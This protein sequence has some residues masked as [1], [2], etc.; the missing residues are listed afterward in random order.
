MTDWENRSFEKASVYCLIFPDKLLICLFH[1]WQNSQNN[2]IMK[3]LGQVFFGGWICLTSAITGLCQSGNCNGNFKPLVFLSEPAVYQIVITEI[4]AD[5]NPTVGLPDAEYLELYNRGEST[6]SLAGCRLIM[7]KNQ[8]VLPA[9]ILESNAYLIICDA[10]SEAQFISSGKTLPMENMPA[11][12]NTGMTVTLKTPSGKVIFS[13]EYSDRWYRSGEKSGGGWSLEMIDPDNICGR[14]DN[15]CES[16]DPRGGTPGSSNSVYAEKPD[17]QMP[18]LLRATLTA[19]TSVLLHFSESMDSTTLNDPS[20]YSANHGLLHPLTVNPV[21]PGYTTTELNFATRLNPGFIYN[22]T[23]LTKLKDCAGNLINNNACV[24]F[25]LPQTPDSTDVVFNE[26][27]FDVP[28][29]RSEFIELYNRS[30][31][32]VDLSGLSLMLCDLHTDTIIRQSSL[33]TNSFLLF[34]GHYVAI[35]RRSEHLPNPNNRLDLSNVVELPQLFI[36]PDREGGIALT[37]SLKKV[38]DL[39]RYSYKMHSE[40]I[41]VTE[42]ISL[43]RIRPDQPTNDQTNWCSASSFAGYS[44]PGYENSQGFSTVQA[45]EK[46]SITPEVFTPDGDGTDDLAVLS[47]DPGGS[48]FTGNIRIF[49]IR[50]IVV[51]TLASHVMFGTETIL[52]WDGMRNDQ[53]PADIGMYLIYIELFNKEGIIKK[54]RKVVTLARK[55]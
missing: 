43:E 13:V 23:I 21:E 12:I 2:W 37:S 20:S 42:G 22:L 7:G 28:S 55:I 41:S 9:M 26:I 45:E 16:S 44:T 14:A 33:K 3:T 40:F 5:P 19:D 1:Y 15:W 6:V 36:L 31:K 53:T 17:R 4:M 18:E 51:K 39:F 47:V 34:P 50:G 29:D 8:K 27:L 11:I 30:E 49:D 54:F 24:S 10:A 52:T 25:G 38:I 35:T 32:I 48:G 46:V